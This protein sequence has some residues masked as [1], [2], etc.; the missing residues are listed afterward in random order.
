M[1]CYK[2]VQQYNI[3]A[4]LEIIHRNESNRGLNAIWVKKKKKKKNI[5]C[6]AVK[7]CM[8]WGLFCTYTRFINEAHGLFGKYYTPTMGQ[9]TKSSQARSV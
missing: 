3:L 7:V 6:A 2:H 8:F 4:C 5:I 1:K 9:R